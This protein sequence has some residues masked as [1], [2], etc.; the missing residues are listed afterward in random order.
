[1]PLVDVVAHSM[2]GLMVP[3]YL[4][5][6]QTSGPPFDPPASVRICNAFFLA[7]PHFGAGIAQLGFG[8]DGQLDELASG[9]RFLFD[10]ATW[11]QGTD[12]LR[13]VESVAAIANGGTGLAVMPGSTMA[14]LALTSA[15]SLSISRAGRR[16]CRIGQQGLH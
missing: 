15:S 13:G 7:A 6:K 12:D 9:S 14:W 8:L 5:R 10:L 2:G 3:C 16:S 11:N 4:S 1:M